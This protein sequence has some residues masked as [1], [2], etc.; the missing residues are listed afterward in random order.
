MNPTHVDRD[1]GGALPVPLA[2]R[3]A[4]LD[5]LA[6]M[7]VNADFWAAVLRIASPLVLGLGLKEDP[8]SRFVALTSP[9]F[10]SFFL[11][12]GLSLFRLRWLSAALPRPF[13]VPGYPVTPVLFCLASLGMAVSSVNFALSHWSE[14]GYWVLAITAVG[15]MASIGSQPNATSGPKR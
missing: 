3:I 11:L 15:I 7:L 13:R 1:A 6:A 12:V 10:W 4:M 14:E 2:L 8:F 5:A 9:V